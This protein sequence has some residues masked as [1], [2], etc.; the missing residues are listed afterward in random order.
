MFVHKKF[1]LAPAVA[2]ALC[3][4][5]ATA[6]AQTDT[7]RPRQVTPTVQPDG[8]FRLET[9]VYLVSEA[10]PVD[11]SARRVSSNSIT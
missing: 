5:A 10:K 2:F 1:P 7:A 11:G 6:A 4:T 9:D 8:A 3:L